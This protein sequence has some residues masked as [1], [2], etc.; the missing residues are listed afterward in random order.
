MPHIVVLSNMPLES[1]CLSIEGVPI[2]STNEALVFHVG[3]D[4]LV[5]S[6]QL[7]KRIDDDTKDDVQQ[8]DNDDEEECRIIGDTQESIRI[9]PTRWLQ[10]VSNTTTASSTVLGSGGCWCWCSCSSRFG[11]III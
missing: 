5:F 6:S 2:D 10:N 3:F 8:Q 4:C 9:V 7:T 1:S 11:D